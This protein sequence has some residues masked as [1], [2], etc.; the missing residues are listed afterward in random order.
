M[1]FGTIDWL[2]GGAWWKQPVGIVCIAVTITCLI[3]FGIILW[4]FIGWLL[5]RKYER[6]YKHWVPG[7]KQLKA[8]R[9]NPR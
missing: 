5:M 3:I 7:S 2:Q 6:D 1:I 8:L 4:G 9:K